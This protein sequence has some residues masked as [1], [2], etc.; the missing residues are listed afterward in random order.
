MS[1]KQLREE[2]DQ[3]VEQ[4]RDAIVA[5]LAEILRFR[6]VSGGESPAEQETFAAETARCLEFLEKRTTSAGFEWLNR[7]NI[8]AA[9]TLDSSLP[10]VGLPVHID[11]VP[12]GDGWSHDPFS[13]EVVDGVIWGRGCQDDKGPVVQMMWAMIILKT[14]GRRLK[15]GARLVVGTMEECGDWE[16]V[17][18]YLAE[19]APPEFSIVAD[20]IFPVINGEKGMINLAIKGSILEDSGADVGGYRLQSATAGERSNIVP[21]EAR[22]VFRGDGESDPQQVRREL[23]RFLKSHP[24]ASAE[25]SESGEHQIE[26]LFRGKSAHGSTPEE[27][28]NAAVDMLAYMTDS[29]FV[30]DDECDMAEFLYECGSDFSGKRLGLDSTH[31]FVGPTTLNLGKLR[32]TEGEVEAIMN[33]RPTLGMPVAHAMKKAQDAVED[34]AQ[35]T[36]FEMTAEARGKVL[37]AIFVD[38]EKHGELLEI[39]KEAYTEYTDRPGVLQAIGGTTYAK[40]FPNAVCFGPVDLSEEEERAHQ[41]DERISVDHLLRNV[42][43]YAYALARLCTS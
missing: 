4:H 41:V 13:G 36:G 11:V 20:A 23:D 12:P 21:P 9:A 16:D 33:I 5:D 38:P 6:T 37:E 30:S 2:I 43:I 28:H 14:L 27:G 15:R 1:D 29:G 24:D 7:D 17:K 8:Y 22:L 31:H 26:I 25:V 34:F 32:W 18:Q 42:R 10:Q 3:L 39:L 35:D 19:Q 40:A